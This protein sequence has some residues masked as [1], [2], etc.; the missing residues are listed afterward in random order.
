MYSMSQAR[1]LSGVRANRTLVD[2]SLAD[3]RRFPEASLTLSRIAGK[4][5]SGDQ[6]G[7]DLCTPQR[8]LALTAS[9]A[10]TVN[11]GPRTLFRRTS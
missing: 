10:R 4:S 9:P 2:R 6:R 1:K 5:G 3:A 11:S 8:A 7:S